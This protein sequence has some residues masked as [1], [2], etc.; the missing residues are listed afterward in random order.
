[1][2]TPDPGD[3]VTAGEPAPPATDRVALDAAGS[4]PEAVTT[5]PEAAVAPGA[6]IE[7]EAPGSAP[8]AVAAEAAWHGPSAGRWVLFAALAVG[9]LVLDQLA[10]GWIT[11]TM[12]VGEW[13]EVLG[14]WLRIVYWQNSGILFGM[15]PQSAPAFAVVSIGVAGLIVFYHWKAG[16]GIVMTIALALLL[17]GAL[18]NLTDRLRYGSVIDF[19]DMGI[20]AWRFYTYNLADAAISTALVLL[21]AMAIFPRIADWGGDA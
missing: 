4:A 12:Q 19:V 1:M 6:E 2:H 20:G 15:L 13:F 11:G 16:R 21:V 7:T 5:D 10:K 9:V 18:G 8:E 17:G 14:D 3:G